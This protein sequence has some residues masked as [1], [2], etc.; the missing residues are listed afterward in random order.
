MKEFEKFVIKPH[1]TSIHL[2]TMPM[3]EY[4]IKY[5]NVFTQSDLDELKKNQAPMRAYWS[6]KKAKGDKTGGKDKQ[7]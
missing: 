5:L 6:G 3:L 4:A 1:M 2:L 7:K